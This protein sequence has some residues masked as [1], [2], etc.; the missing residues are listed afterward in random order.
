MCVPVGLAAG[1]CESEAAA[2]GEAVPSPSPCGR[3]FVAPAQAA[4]TA[5]CSLTSYYS[6]PLEAGYKNASVFAEEEIERGGGG[7]ES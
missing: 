1:G 6:A 7:R 4:S 5:A 2:V 3:H